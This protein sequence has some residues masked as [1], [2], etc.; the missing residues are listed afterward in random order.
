[1]TD[2]Q[3]TLPDWTEFNRD[4]V[5]GGIPHLFIVRASPM[6]ALFVDQGA[7]RLGARFQTTN[8]KSD[9]LSGM[10]A[11]IHVADIISEASRAVEIWTDSKNHYSNFYLLISEIVSEV[12]D[13][14]AEPDTAL[15]AAIARWEALLSRPTLMSEEAQAGLFGE[16]WLLERLIAN[17]GPGAVD[18]W[19]GPVPQPHDFRIG[20]IELEVKTTSG[21][22]RIHTINGIGQ[23]QPS[24]NCRLY[25]VSLKLANAGTG[26]RSLPEAVSNIEGLLDHHPAA[27]KRFRDGL[28]ANSYNPDHADRYPRRRRL[29]DQA[30]LIE[31]VDGVPRLTV[32]AL[33]AIDP[34]FAPQRFGRITY[35]INVEGLGFADGSEPFHSVLPAIKA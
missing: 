29:R 23:L 25:L 9:D 15:L 31:V 34:R 12:V 26:G 13:D 11:E 3:T 8:T 20:E 1:M 32:E 2:M 28:T 33:G 18:A 10:L 5:A 24:L 22:T 6:V 16:L 19:V 14:G 21:A 4:Y 27:L 7:A 35:D 30:M 17:M